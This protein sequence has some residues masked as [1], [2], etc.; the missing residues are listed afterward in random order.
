MQ[1]GDIKNKMKKLAVVV[2]RYGIEVN[3]G[4]EYHARVLAEKLA[5][6][7]SVEI[8]TTT[9]IDYKNW[10]NH[11]PEGIEF[12]NN[13][14]VFRFPTINKK[15]KA[16]K[17]A[18]R[19]LI[20]SFKISRLLQTFS[21]LNFFEKKINITNVSE[22]HIEN[23]IDG[24]GPYCP[25][26]I[27][28]IAKNKNSYDIFIFFTYLYYPTVKGMPL[29]AEK[30]IFVPT[31]HNEK[32][33]FTKAYEEIFSIPKFI[34]YNTISEKKL[35]ENHFKN[36]SENSDFAGVGIEKYNDEIERL[37]EGLN[38]KKYFLYIGRIDAA[39]GCEQLLKYYMSFI[40]KHPNYKDY[41]LVLVGKNHMKKINHPNI[42]YTGFVNESLKYSLLKNA[43]ALL[44]S[45]FYESLS[46]VTL[47]AM[48]EGIP[49]IINKKC[50]V[51][52]NHILASNTGA[53]YESEETF[54]V[55]LENY[56]N[57]SLESLINEGNLAQKYVEKNY[58]WQLILEK[59][60]KAINLITQK[61]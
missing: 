9:A 34:M 4:A 39:K 53:A 36:I 24:Q 12:I 60:E 42:I 10:E 38:P 27:Q 47:E 58:R 19:K 29:V 43:K 37:P 51:L 13:I 59:F 6:K 3:G 56:I 57:K 21:I 45:S 33:L 31:A 28:Y 61:G 16:T 23:W 11:Y 17:I 32:I 25:D 50:E 7:Y 22:K 26:L 8:L 48:N 15:T 46:L 1:Y 49:V 55:I 44:M 40:K 18:R 35:V 5:K 2:Q 41:L 20:L 30:S 52:Y 14:R 54:S